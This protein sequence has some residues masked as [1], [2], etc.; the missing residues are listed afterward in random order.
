MQTRNATQRARR[1][2]WIHRSSAG[3]LAGVLL[4]TCRPSFAQELPP[5]LPPTSVNDAPAATDVTSSP[6]TDSPAAG[7]VRPG[8]LARVQKL[9][10]SLPDAELIQVLERRGDL[11]LQAATLVEALFTLRTQWKVDMV[12]SKNIEG[13]VNA[14][15]QNASLREI[16]DSLLL[17]AGSGIRSSARASSCCRSISLAR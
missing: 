6:E 12:V 8:R 5:V 4:V 17:S 2:R 3:L 1:S 13:E 15:F 14:T 16:L 10:A 9:P 7:S 11:T